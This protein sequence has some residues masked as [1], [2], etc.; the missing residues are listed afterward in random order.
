MPVNYRY[1]IVKKICRTKKS[2][3]FAAWKN[4]AACDHSKKML[5]RVLL[6]FSPVIFLLIY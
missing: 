2:S 3:I 6:Y 1:K 5:K 4:L